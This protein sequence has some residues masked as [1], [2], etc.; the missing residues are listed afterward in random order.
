MLTQVRKEY[1]K[2][3]RHTYC[4]GG[5]PTE[6]SHGSAKTSTTRTSARYSSGTQVDQQLHTVRDS[7]CVKKEKN[8]VFPAHTHSS[9]SSFTL[10]RIPKFKQLLMRMYFRHEHVGMAPKKC[11][12]CILVSQV[13]QETQTLCHILQAASAVLHEYLSSVLPPLALAFIFFSLTS[14]AWEI[15]LRCIKSI[16]STFYYGES[17]N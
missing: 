1:S 5:L 13:D 11:T 16:A 15:V 3:F 17:Q 8:T 12:S 4:C 14:C 6:S 7:P 10:L 9:H 2:C